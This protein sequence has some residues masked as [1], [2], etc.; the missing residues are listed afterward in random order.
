MTTSPT[1]TITEDGQCLGPEID[2]GKEIN[3]LQYY[4]E[5]ADELIEIGDTIEME[6]ATKRVEVIHNKI[7][8]LTGQIEEMKLEQGESSR[9]VRQWKKDTKDKYV[10]MLEQNGKM[11]RAL[12]RIEN[13]SREEHLK[14]ELDRKEIEQQREDKRML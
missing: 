4:T 11:L 7:I 1:E 6:I 2:I 13:Q 14:R 8:N 12:S 10:G 3:K 5:Q 9:S